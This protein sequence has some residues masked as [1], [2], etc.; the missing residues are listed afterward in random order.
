[1]WNL[2]SDFNVNFLCQNVI[3]GIDT[4][5]QKSKWIYN[6]T[7]GPEIKSSSGGGFEDALRNQTP[8]I[9]QNIWMMGTTQ[10]ALPDSRGFYST[11]CM[12]SRPSN[13][14][15]PSMTDIK[16]NTTMKFNA[17]YGAFRE[18]RPLA[19]GEGQAY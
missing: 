2:K 16:V 18:G 15:S 9:D 4:Q 8:I 17:G 13:Y 14:N 5:S 3:T 19:S 12:G 1:M 7:A 11:S 10:I 6:I